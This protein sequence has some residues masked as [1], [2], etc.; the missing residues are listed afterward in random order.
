MA[1]KLKNIWTNSGLKILVF[2]LA[3]VF[4]TLCF[5]TWFQAMEIQDGLIP[6][7][8]NYLE[9]SELKDQVSVAYYDILQRYDYY[10]SEDNIR[11]GKNLSDERLAQFKKNLARSS[12]FASAID[13]GETTLE[14]VIGDPT[15]L[16]KFSGEIETQRLQYINTDIK[17][18]NWYEGQL[19]QIPGLSYY[20][21]SQGIIKAYPENAMRADI[22]ANRVVFSYDN[23]SIISTLPNI[24]QYSFDDAQGENFKVS[25]AFNDTYIAE[26]E[27]LYQNK[28]AEFKQMV[29]FFIV[30]FLGALISGI[31]ACVSAGHKKDAAGIILLKSDSVYIELHLFI[32]FIIEGFLLAGMFFVYSKNLPLVLMLLIFGAGAALGLNFLLSLIRIIKD[33]SFTQHLLSW[34]ISKRIYQSI[35]ELI[36]KCWGYYNEVMKG[37]S[38]VKRFMFFCI[39]LV[40]LGLALSIPLIGILSLALI[41]Y[42]LYAG[43][44]RAHKYDEMI[45]GM[46][47][48]KNGEADYK[49]T[50][51]D[52]VLGE[53]AEGINAIG[54]GITL[55]VSKEV[56][57][58]RL[59]TEL[60]TNVSHDIR[61]PLTSIITSIDL[62]KNGELNPEEKVKYLNILEN[63]AQRLKTLTDDLFEAAKA[64][65]GNIEVN[66]EAIDLEILM[67]QGLGEM[68]EELGCSQLEFI[69]QYP[70]QLLVVNAD[71][72]LLWRVIQNLLSNILKYAQKESRVYLE[73][74]KNEGRGMI[75]F[76]NISAEP[77]NISP[78][79][80]VERFKR[81]DETRNSEGSGLGL[82]IAKD[83][84]I[85]QEGKLKIDIDGDLFKAVLI[86]PLAE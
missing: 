86:L 81:G 73:L 6:E 78:E 36:N 37:S 25:L 51:F 59:K 35:K 53:L 8:E 68:E 13:S 26:Q 50:G 31:L 30:F 63:K 27:G 76:K 71:G 41:V 80:L 56:Q 77:L 1:T 43:G 15:F 11:T 34:K 54:E 24:N 32:L 69:T 79:E 29:I 55:A 7:T 48:I 84:M 85:I 20:V 58:Q 42:I 39:G 18:L 17:D 47:R 4:M 65:T 2:S 9:S 14:E 3:V 12:D 61:T 62:L 16:E 33:R 67:T 70:K 19:Q 10:I 45:H 82:A 57:S 64:S 74:I 75:V 46:E 40:I 83:L 49:L 60:I 5:G 72:R 23:G 52:G 38:F 28:R 22:L 44:K 21:E 66:F